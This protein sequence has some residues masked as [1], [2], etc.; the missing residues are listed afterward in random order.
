MA[1]GA[2][3]E[4]VYACNGPHYPIAQRRDA[5]KED[6][7]AKANTWRNRRLR[8]CIDHN[9]WLMTLRESSF[10]VLV[11]G[12]GPAGAAA[13]RALALAGVPVT[14]LDRSTFPRNKPCGGGISAR[15]LDRF[16]YLAPV[17][18]RIATH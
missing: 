11:V 16:P 18:G 5:T 10:P 12:A 7:C 8:K 9:R 13:A 14:L 6:V 3:M 2:F 17:L 15:V 1:R 4:F